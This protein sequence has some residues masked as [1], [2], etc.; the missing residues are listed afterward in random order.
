MNDYLHPTTLFRLL[1]V[2]VLVVAPHAVRLP[3][4][5]S[6]LIALL[7]GWRAVAA[8]RQWRMPHSALKAALTIAAF[9]GVYLTYNRVSGQSAG[10]ALLV[11]ML[12]L[13]LTEL[14]ARRDVMVLVF[15]MYFILI[16]HFLFSQE[17]WTIAY[18]FGS[19]MAITA[20]L[21]DV[22]HAGA[23]LSTRPTLR[24]A[25][26]IVVQAVPL[27]LL[28]FVLFPRVP[29][30]LWGLPADSGSARSGLSDSMS[31]GDIARLIESSEVAFRVR[32]EG[33]P[34]AQQDLYWRG[35]V[36]WN[37]DGRTWEPG[38]RGPREAQAP[39]ASLG[40]KRFRYE[41]V[42]EP[43]RTDW[44]FAIDLP[45]QDR[46]PANSRLNA[47]YQL[48]SGKI[49]RE[50]ILYR[51]ES[52]PDYLLEPE[53]DEAQRRAT[54]RIP[55]EGNAGA[56]EL[57]QTWRSEV[58]SDQAFVERVL[59]HFR[60]EPF[61]YTLEPPRLSRNSVDDFLFE[62]RRGF[63]EHYASSFTFL[64]RAAGIPAR[65]VTGYQ[66]GT[67]NAFSDYFVV[68][69][70]DA[71]AWSEVWLPERGW[72]RVDPTAAVAPNRIE[73]GINDALGLPDQSADYLAGRI[74]WIRVRYEFEA[75]WD[76]A[77]AQWNRWVLAYGP[78]LQQELFGQWGLQGW[79][80]LLLALTLAVSAVLAVVGWVLMRRSAPR[81]PQ[82]RALRLWQAAGRRLARKGLVQRPGEGP[83]DF[84]DRVIHER[85]ALEPA[86]SAAVEAYLR[87][88]YANERS[89][90]LERRLA[91]AVQLIKRS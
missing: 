45:A 81:R 89:G 87:L 22:S 39:V 29:G 14:R 6:A 34:P 90:D 19:A 33:D 8:L 13:K 44:L 52:A 56:R 66:G 46:L 86:M 85:P 24:L 51:A 10:V 2:L 69:Q 61:F 55:R 42:L 49:V 91:E 5:E 3:A 83:R 58:G 20:V 74:S 64:M 26:A 15:L 70:S 36:F 7:M 79:R 32:F 27:M 84:A 76:L 77:N 78:E 4:W 12:V 60:N 50:R 80:N 73:R 41:V 31:P 67:R 25:G 53:L 30:P 17:I 16:T 9:V 88:R 68:R 54:T 65:V 37:F 57:A 82:E 18:L 23:P 75:R 38:F 11:A 28:M 62:S 59:G 72:V 71:H 48:L 63:C 1:A 40:A 21:I 43:T 47:D 35:P